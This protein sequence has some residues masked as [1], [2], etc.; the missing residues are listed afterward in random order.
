MALQQECK[1]SFKD[2]LRKP[3]RRDSIM[4][5]VPH[6]GSI[7]KMAHRHAWDEQKSQLP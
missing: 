7:M 5:M 3:S 4:N 6:H 2:T 1:Q